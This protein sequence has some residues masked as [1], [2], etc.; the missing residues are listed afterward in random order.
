M[1]READMEKPIL[2]AHQHQN[3][4]PLFMQAPIKSG[5]NSISALRLFDSL[6]S[7]GICFMNLSHFN[8]VY[9]TILSLLW[10]KHHP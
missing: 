8:K 6:S 1:E 2:M 4:C 9:F 3:Y 7:L 10:N 5:Y